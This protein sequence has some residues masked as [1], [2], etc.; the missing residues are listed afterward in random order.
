MKNRDLEAKIKAEQQRQDKLRFDLQNAKDHISTYQ[1]K[2][3][4]VHNSQSVS[5]SCIGK[6]DE[7][8]GRVTKQKKQLLDMKSTH[9]QALEGQRLLVQSLFERINKKEQ[10]RQTLIRNST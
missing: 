9:K 7:V 4:L 2:L 3:K 10:E 1:N 8:R 5:D 6:R